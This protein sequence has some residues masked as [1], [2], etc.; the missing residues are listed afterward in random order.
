MTQQVSL[1][2][3]KC[4][5]VFISGQWQLVVQVETN[6]LKCLSCNACFQVIGL[7][8]LWHTFGVLSGM[9][10]HLHGVRLAQASELV[11]DFKAAGDLP[12][13]HFRLDGEPWA[14]PLAPGRTGPVRVSV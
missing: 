5:R 2:C 4:C 8:G 1:F 11:F 6:W 14:Q 10:R 3:S 12:I 9:N 13:T 7:K